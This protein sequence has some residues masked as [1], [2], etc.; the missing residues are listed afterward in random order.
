MRGGRREGAGRPRGAKNKRTREVEAAME[1]VAAKFAEAVPDA[2]EGDSVAFLQ[3]VYK[4]PTLPFPVRLDA[5]AKAA[6]FERP[7]LSATN[8]RMIRS[9]HDLS[10]EELAS[11]RA[12]AEK[13]A[14]D[15]AAG[16]V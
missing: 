14:A 16:G 10:D 9:L 1:T 6:R 15:L 8:M 3:T 11:V 5:A 7:I 13:E 12:E 2:F 4:N